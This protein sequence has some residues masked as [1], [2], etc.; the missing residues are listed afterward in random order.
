MR[1]DSSHLFFFQSCFAP[2]ENKHQ[3]IITTAGKHEQ[4]A[5]APLSPFR[6][7]AEKTKAQ[8]ARSQTQDITHTDTEKRRLDVRFT[9][10]EEL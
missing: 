9:D 2:N 3:Q 6:V 10:V 7:I 1:T 5:R 4:L 8:K